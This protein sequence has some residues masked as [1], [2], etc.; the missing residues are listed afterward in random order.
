MS[1]RDTILAFDDLK[2]ESVEVPE[3]GNIHLTIK[4]MN[5]TQRVAWEQVAFKEGTPADHYIA[6]LLVHTLVDDDGCAIFSDA[7]IPALLKKKWSV[8]RRLYDSAATLN[9]LSKAA[10]DDAA[11]N[12]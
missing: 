10:Q 12:S 2:H 1:K 6:S 3:W 11:K 9:G 8:V 7:D 5:G 4:E